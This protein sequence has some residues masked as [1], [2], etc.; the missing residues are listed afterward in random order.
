[1]KLYS[2][3]IDG[4]S[5][6]GDFT[7]EDDDPGYLPIITICTLEAG[8]IDLLLVIDPLVIHEIEQKLLEDYQWNE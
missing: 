5:F 4:I 1:M 3:T 6:K 7:I 2:Y 8:G